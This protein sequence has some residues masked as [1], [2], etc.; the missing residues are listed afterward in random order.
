[1]FRRKSVSKGNRGRG[2]HK[3]KKAVKRLLEKPTP[4]RVAA[5]ADLAA[6][7]NAQPFSVSAFCLYISC[8]MRSQPPPPA[9]KNNLGAIYM[10]S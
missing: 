4:D 10:Y 7:E 1:M 8:I 3:A 9:K 2:G 6:H 5:I